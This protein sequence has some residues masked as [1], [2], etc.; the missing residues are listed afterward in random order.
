[1]TV[2]YDVE[3]LTVSATTIDK[4]VAMFRLDPT[5]FKF[6]K[7]DLEGT[8]LF[9]L[10]G[11]A[12]VLLKGRPLV[13]FENGADSRITFNYTDGDFEA[14]LERVGYQLISI[15]GE[16]LTRNDY[17]FW[18]MF[19]APIEHVDPLSILIKGLFWGA[20]YRH[21]TEEYRPIHTPG[22]ISDDS[23]D[24]TVPLS[25]IMPPDIT[26]DVPTRIGKMDNMQVFDGTRVIHENIVEPVPKVFTLEIMLQSDTIVQQTNA[27]ND[28]SPPM[29]F[30]FSGTMGL[31]QVPNNRYKLAV[32]KTGESTRADTI[33]ISDAGEAKHIAVVV[34]QGATA[35]VFVDGRRVA[36]RKGGR[37]TGTLTLGKGYLNRTWRGSIGYFRISRGARY[38]DAFIPDTICKSDAM[39]IYLLDNANGV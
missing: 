26:V 29:P 9:A 17:G 16:P 32:G 30:I 15:Y 4:D 34:D 36:L 8:E 23:L 20:F 39:T 12:N 24:L 22:I 11:A 5:K 18:Y 31:Y 6:I 38:S 14:F 37:Y 33:Y 13:A 10:Q 25:E 3:E 27:H 1:M 28:T 2:E 21:N 7:L 35:T 19:C